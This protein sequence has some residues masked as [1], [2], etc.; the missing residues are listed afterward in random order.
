[1]AVTWTTTIIH[2]TVFGNKRVVTA[3]IEA[4]GTSTVTAVGDAYAPSALGLRGFDIVMMSGFS[5]SNTGGATQTAAQSVT[6]ADTG[7]FPVYNYTQ[8]SISVHHLGPA[9]LASVGP[10]VVATGVNITGA[11]IRIM[12]VGY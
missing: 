12:A 11:K 5:L 7:Y 9:D 4:T 3:D 10:S 2:E 6:A 8:E 1:M